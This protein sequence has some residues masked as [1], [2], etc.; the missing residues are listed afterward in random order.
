MDYLT[1]KELLPIEVLPSFLKEIVNTKDDTSSAK[2]ADDLL[3]PFRNDKLNKWVML[4][5]FLDDSAKRFVQYWQGTDEFGF[6]WDDNDLELLEFLLYDHENFEFPF[7]CE[8]VTD[9]RSGQYSAGEEAKANL[10]ISLYDAY[11]RI[12]Q[13]TDSVTRQI[14][15]PT[16]CSFAAN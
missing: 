8:L 14:I 6:Y 16:Y 15:V 9:N 7:T 4:L 1:K 12:S 5:R 13:P 3:K 11:M 10:F 2:L